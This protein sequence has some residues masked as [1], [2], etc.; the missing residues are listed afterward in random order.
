MAFHSED[1]PTPEGWEVTHREMA[2]I[3][4][5]HTDISYPAV[6]QLHLSWSLTEQAEVEETD[7]G[8]LI[9]YRIRVVD[10]KD[11]LER[12]TVQAPPPSA[13]D[14]DDLFGEL[15]ALMDKHGPD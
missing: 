8:G 12:R 1:V 4:W 6:L 3:T 9:D 15:N 2:A 5:Q 7:G 13:H 10:A 11:I 14:H